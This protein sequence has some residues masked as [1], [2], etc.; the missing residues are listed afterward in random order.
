MTGKERADVGDDILTSARLPFL[1]YGASVISEADQRPLF[2]VKIVKEQSLGSFGK[3]SHEPKFQH[4]I[5]GNHPQEPSDATPKLPG[6][7]CIPRTL[8]LF[9]HC[10][11]L[12]QSQAYGIGDEVSQSS[13]SKC[14]REW[15]RHRLSSEASTEAEHIS[16]GKCKRPMSVS[17]VYQGSTNWHSR[18]VHVK[19]GNPSSALY[20]VDVSVHAYFRSG[21]AQLWVVHSQ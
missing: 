6:K 4:G 18:T 8:Q 13:P 12:M 20:I 11:L 2:L 1:C 7:P 21:S 10:K 14:A 15:H 17:N 19:C 9:I 3:F 5:A 16:S